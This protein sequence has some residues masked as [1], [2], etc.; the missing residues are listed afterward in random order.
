MTQKSGL[1]SLTVLALLAGCHGADSTKDTNG[2]PMSDAEAVA[3][4][5]RMNQTPFKPLV[6]Q[7]IT[8]DDKQRYGID[9]PGCSFIRIQDSAPILIAGVNEGFMKLNGKVMRMAARKESAQLPTGARTTF[10][11][12]KVWASLARQPDPD[13]DANGKHFPARM[14]VHDSADRVAFTADGTIECQ[15]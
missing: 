13:S 9:Q 2:K 1:M 3:M 12:L 11:G 8:S 14:I 10:I 7:P 6:P 5:K 4:V 15:S